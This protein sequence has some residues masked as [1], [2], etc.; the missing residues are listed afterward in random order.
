MQ[1]NL[2]LHCGAFAV[3]RDASNRIKTPEGTG[4]FRPIAHRQL[5][6]RVLT[7]V[8]A[9]GWSLEGEAHALNETGNTY[10]G[11]LQVKPLRVHGDDDHGFVIG[12]RNANNR[13][14]AAGLAFGSV[15]FVCD[16]LAFSGAVTAFRKHTKRL[17]E[18]LPERVRHAVEALPQASRLI[19]RRFLDYRQ[20]AISDE[21]AHDL[22][23]KALDAKVI[24][25]D[26]IPTVLTGW[27]TPRHPELATDG[28]TAWRLF[29]AFTEAFKKSS[30]WNVAHRGLAFQELFGRETGPFGKD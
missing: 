14:L 27:R 22:I 4:T 10:F 11:L 7:S 6:D 15:V 18:D 20:R 24:G 28:K 1:A 8:E 5:L 16:N 9:L 26:L 23:V 3:D 13:R 21:K 12:L 2:C 29:N 30:I 25:T 17:H 19:Q